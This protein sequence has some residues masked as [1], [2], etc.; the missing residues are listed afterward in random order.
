MERNSTFK[1]ITTSGLVV[2]VLA[3]SCISAEAKAPPSKLIGQLTATANS[4]ASVAVF[5]STPP[6]MISGKEGA[7]LIV[8]APQPTDITP[9]S[10]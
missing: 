7:K 2:A 5:H 3:H 9:R 1:I 6:N 4:T 8:Q 10:S